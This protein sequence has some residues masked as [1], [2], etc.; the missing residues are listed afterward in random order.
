[1]ETQNERESKQEAIGYKL[2]EL[3]S[4]KE[5]KDNNGKRYNPP[6]YNTSYGTKTAI[7]L[8][9]SVERIISGE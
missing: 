3:L 4:L 2:V 5:A 9:L 7:G 8:A 6:R 1:M